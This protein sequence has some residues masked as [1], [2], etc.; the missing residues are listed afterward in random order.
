MASFEKIR[1]A[2]FMPGLPDSAMLVGIKA[3]IADKPHHATPLN[4]RPVRGNSG[5]SS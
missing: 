4:V 3:S 5:S 1:Q 2:R